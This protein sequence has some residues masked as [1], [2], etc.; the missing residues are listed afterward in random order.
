MFH[1]KVSFLKEDNL[2]YVFELTA[3]LIFSV[4]SGIVN[5]HVTSTCGKI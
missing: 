1:F 3:H 4:L 2:S 5:I